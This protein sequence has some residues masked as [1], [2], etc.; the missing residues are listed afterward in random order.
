[1][2]KR[3]NFEDYFT[4]CSNNWNDL[5]TNLEMAQYDSVEYT[6]KKKKFSVEYQVRLDFERNTIQCIFQQTA[7]KSDWLTNFTFPHK[8]YDKFTFEGKTIQLK[9][10]RG[11]GDMWLACQDIVRK[12]VQ[13][14]L[15]IY[16]DASIEVFGW[17]LGSALA[18][19]CAEDI[20]FKFGLKPYLYTYGSVK[21]F[22]G[23]QTLK[24]VQQCCEE[25][26]NFY[27][28]NDIVGRMVP[29]IGWKAINH[30]KVKLTSRCFFKLFNPQKYHT[31]YDTKGLYT[32][33]EK[34]M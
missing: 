21:P 34:E 9:V 31:K 25:A 14:L 15:S 13:V 5:E 24:Y 11:W 20:Y 33:Y 19:L 16:P 10:H 12:K 23:K 18:Q 30:C 32:K 26:Y 6:R 29:F 27:D 8:I 7:S 1:M 4:I 22:Y 17:S 3:L 28:V 2:Y